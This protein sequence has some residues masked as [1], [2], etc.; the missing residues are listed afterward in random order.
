MKNGE[1]S[2]REEFQQILLL[3][4]IDIS[5]EKCI[6]ERRILGEWQHLFL[7][8]LLAGQLN[9]ELNLADNDFKTYFIWKDSQKRGFRMAG[10]EEK[11]NITEEEQ[12]DLHK[13]KNFL[14]T[15]IQLAEERIQEKKSI[16][17]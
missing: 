7:I 5:T 11:P 1:L 6:L 8:K 17:D 4:L 2:T 15:M 12:K 10:P 14:M 13:C 3:D 9:M 16:S